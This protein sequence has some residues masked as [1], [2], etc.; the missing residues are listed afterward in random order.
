MVSTIIDKINTFKKVLGIHIIQLEDDKYQIDVCLLEKRKGEIYILFQ[1]QYSQLCQ[2]S[3]SHKT[4]PCSISIQS[5]NILHKPTDFIEDETITK[6][7][8]TNNLEQF[9]IEKV[10]TGNSYFLSCIRK[11]DLISILEELEAS[12][13]NIAAL[14]ISPAHVI[15][16]SPYLENK[17]PMEINIEGYKLNLESQDEFSIHT[18]KKHENALSSL[19]LANVNLEHNQIIS[20]SN[21]LTILIFQNSPN[22]IIESGFNNYTDEA[23]YKILF[24]KTWRP[25]I[26]TLFFILLLNFLLFQNAGS[27]FNILSIEFAKYQKKVNTLNQLQADYDAKK[28]IV[29]NLNLNTRNT[30]T[31]F[32]DQIAATVP[33]N[34]K[35]HVLNLFPINKERDG[36]EFN[37]KTNKNLIQISG[38]C[39]S[40]LVLNGWYKELRKFDFVFE[41]EDQQ[42]KY[43]NIEGMAIFS[44]NIRLSKLAID[45]I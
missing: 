28:D 16:C 13:L 31:Y 30:N 38:E 22:Y 12:T 41:I 27:K 14:S 4:I 42:Y 24:N 6:Y 3:E 1:Q 29:A 11:E 19:T 23:K 35:L 40:P 17:F 2:L 39:S 7:L 15:A 34:I 21:A 8:H 10:K 33:S 36:L 18:L 9:Y 37:Y 25:G 20:Y 32:I 5:K 43:D 45:E 44:F 26:L